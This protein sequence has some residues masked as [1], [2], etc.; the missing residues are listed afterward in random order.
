MRVGRDM[1][2]AARVA[3][4]HDYLLKYHADTVKRAG[5]N[6]LQNI[7]HDSLIITK[8]KGFVH[9]SI[10][11]SGNGIDYL[12]EYLGYSFTR[13]VAALAAF[14]VGNGY[15]ATETP[16]KPPE[17]AKNAFRRVFAYLTVTRG[18]PRTVVTKL[19]ADKLLI[20]DEQHN[21]C[22][23]SKQCNYAELNGTYTNI[24]FK[25]ISEGSESNGY[26]LIGNESADTVYICE[27]AIDAV[28]LFA[29]AQKKQPN[30]DSYAVASIGGLKPAAVHRLMQDFKTCVI[31]VDNDAAGDIF[32]EEFSNLRRIKPNNKDWNEDILCK[33]NG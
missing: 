22:F 15:T 33:T 6:R 14:S 23:V 26:W 5:H 1:I 7:E 16:Y 24:R 20:E 19:I 17:A 28:S 12:T 10:N 31:A 29:L 25:G 11:R 32:A 13:A 2:T 27:S 30:N 21:C 18:I 9:N 3:D 4:L 8:G